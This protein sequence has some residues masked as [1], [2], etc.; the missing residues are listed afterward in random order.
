MTTD[1]ISAVLE[2]VL[3]GADDFHGTHPWQ[4]STQDII[5]ACVRRVEDYGIKLQGSGEDCCDS[6]FNLGGEDKFQYSKDEDEQGNPAVLIVLT[7]D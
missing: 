5:N 7:E 6:R 2:G 4:A 1:P 3:L